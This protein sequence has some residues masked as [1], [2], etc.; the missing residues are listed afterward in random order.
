MVHVTSKANRRGPRGDISANDLAAAASRVLEAT[1]PDGLSLRAVAAEA[2]VAPNAVYTYFTDMSEL[3]NRLG[4]DFLG[5]LDL[6]VLKGDEPARAMA[7]FLAQVLAV[8]AAAPG[9]VALLAEQ[10]I[11]GEHSLALNEGLLDFFVDRAGHSLARAAAA[12]GMLTEWVHGV[13][14]LSSSEANVGR[15]QERLAAFDPAR[16]P[17]TASA[18]GLPADDDAAIELFVSV[19]V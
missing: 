15:T 5:R 12:T 4:D 16:Y 14:V 8:F 6:E 10:R 18:F 19:L 1:G 9:Q 13:A 7:E 17:R 11:I 3:R 2:G